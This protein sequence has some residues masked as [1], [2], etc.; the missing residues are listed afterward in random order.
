MEFVGWSVVTYVAEEVK[1][2]ERTLPRALIAG[3]LILTALYLLANAGY[4][5]VLSPHEVASVA[6]TSSVAG[7]VLVRLLGAGG[8]ALIGPAA[9]C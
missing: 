9:S 1:S 3:S 5:Y 4:F 7:A 6:E 2:P 8:A